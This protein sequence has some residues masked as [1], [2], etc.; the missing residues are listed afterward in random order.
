VPAGCGAAA[1]LDEKRLAQTGAVGLTI[2][3]QG[4]IA[5]ATDRGVDE[6][7][8]WSP[9]PRRPRSDRI[10]RPGAAIGPIRADPADPTIDPA[11]PR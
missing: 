9:A 6:D 8:P 4:K 10:E 1:V 7:R 2:D 3:E 11:D 5:I